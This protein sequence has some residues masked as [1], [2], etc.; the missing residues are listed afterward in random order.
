MYELDAI[1]AC[2]IGGASLMGGEGNALATLAGALIMMVLRNFCN[3]ENLDV[4]W[5]QVLV[6]ALLIVLV[7]Y[8]SY[9]KRAY[10]GRSST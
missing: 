4:Y 10:T 2:V 1:A 6:G 3:L 9:Q 5:Q 8:D 7:F